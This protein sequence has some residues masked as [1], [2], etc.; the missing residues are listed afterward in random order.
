MLEKGKVADLLR[1]AGEH[2]Q[3]IAPVRGDELRYGVVDETSEIVLGT[4]PLYPAK[5][6][7][8][9]QREALFHFEGNTLT[10]RIPEPQAKVLFG[11]RRCDL[12]AIA[13]QD[14]A[15]TKEDAD[16]YY[17]RRRE[18]TLL[19]GIHC[20]TAMDEYCFCTSMQLSHTCQDIMLYERGESY[21]V[22]ATTDAGQAFIEQHRTFFEESE[23]QLRDE[24]CRTDGA[25]TLKRFDMNEAFASEAWEGTAS[26]C[27]DCGACNTLCP[28]CYCF[29]IKDESSLPD[30]R[31]GER[32]R[33]WSMC[34]LP[35]FTRVAGDHIFRDSL[36]ARFKHR[37]YHQLQW[38]RE[39]HGVD[40]CVGCGRCIRGCPPRIDFRTTIN[41]LGGAPHG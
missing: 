30:V 31:A 23:E 6:F 12:N 37:I 38:F 11:L 4:L 7:F 16:P 3:V 17:A 32:V 29:E 21:L 41:Q 36:T 33:T 34:M 18:Q 14:I 8:F 19:I 39:R 26:A 28:T 22:E 35:E 1:A 20:H 9:P 13:H 24:D 2:A 40:L 5:R 15:F 25:D 27:I 10:Q